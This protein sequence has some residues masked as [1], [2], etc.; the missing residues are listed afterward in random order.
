MFNQKLFFMIKNLKFYLLVCPA[1]ILISIKALMAQTIDRYALDGALY[2]KFKD[3]AQMNFSVKA[4]KVLPENI[5]FLSELK[6]KY[7]ITSVR[8][9]FWQTTDSKLHRIFKVQFEKKEL[10]EQFIRDLASVPDVEYAEKAPYFPIRFTPN[11]YG[12]SAGNRWHL[13]K[14]SA[15][16]AWDIS[17]G[18]SSIKV[19]VI[20]NAIQVG[21]SDLSS[22][23]VAAI[24]LGDNDNDPTPPSNTD[25][26]SHGT[27]TSGLA[28]AATNNN[29]GISSIGFDCSLIAIKAG[30]DADGGQGISAMF[31]GITWA[32]DH[33][34]DIIS[35]SFGGPSYFQTMQMIVDY[36]YNKGCVLVAAAGNNGDGSEDQN[37]VN[38]IGYPAACNH[39]IAVGAT[40]GND[41]A[42]SFSE[43]GTWID[44]MAPGGYQNDG[45]F[46][47]MISNNSVYSCYAGNSYGKMPGTSMACPITAGLC[48]LMKSV[49]P[50]ISVDRLTYFLKASCDNIEALQDAN[51]QGMVGAGRINAFNAVKMVQDSMQSIYANFTCSGNFI[52]AGG[53]VNF[54]DQSVGNITSW[55]WSFPGGNPATSNQQNP[56]NITYDTPGTYAVTLTV[57]DGTHSS[58]ETKTAYITVQQPANTAWIEQASGFTTLYRGVYSISI[59]ND[60]IA[61]ATAVDGTN[62]SP[63][64]EFTKT[65]NGGNLWTPGTIN[66]PAGLAPAN[67]SAVSD[68]KAWVAEYPTNGAGGKVYATTDG[69]ATWVNQNNSTMFTN[70]ASFLNIVHFFNENDG[71]CMGDPISGNFE[72]YYTHDG[73]TTWTA[74]ASANNPAAQSGEMGW[75]G[76]Y[77]AYNNIAWFGTNKGRI[78]KTTDK[79]ETWTVLTP[80]LTD[81]QKVTFNNEMNGITQQITYSSGTISSLNMKKTTDGGLNWTTVTPGA[82]FWKSDICAVP[83]VPGKYF[84]VGS[85]GAANASYGSS[86]SLDFGAT[87]TPIDT[88]VQYI[89]VE[90]LNE[91]TGWAGGFSTN[92]TTS[93]VF[94]WDY[95][96]NV[97]SVQQMVNISV[98]P[99]PA[100]EFVTVES[101]EKINSIEV[102]NQ[103]GQRMMNQNVN[104]LKSNLSLNRFGKGIY[105]LKVNTDK[106]SNIYKVIVK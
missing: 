4:G 37:N 7:G 63:V 86:Y 46:L 52:N 75:T 21:H 85:N 98:Y 35:M 105:L 51:H 101:S 23:V 96:T 48:A 62:G 66:A 102:I 65:T 8:N 30:A 57:S 34:A 12:S 99:N 32:A 17:H 78:Y 88:G 56:Q 28:V 87:W 5:P 95:Q 47:D 26:W 68:M 14:I 104:S 64:N 49:D 73:G 79:G 67:I 1:V 39:V 70:S 16:Q 60:T 45:G 92:A 71:F 9:T 40:N 44:V 55:N 20:D 43:Y 50:N 6:D 18:S 58:T 38:Y 89:S 94:K 42:A 54:T 74:V 100:S 97:Q 77:D 29:N 106:G 61:W 82:N 31:E 76:V 59:V 25:I 22:K 2:F 69:G 80:G 19:A 84:S 90:F 11:D 91:Q 3:H 33:D 81:I 10:V 83:D 24:D 72:I 13:D 15:Q 53:H 36:A 103:L 93:G 41:K 27:H